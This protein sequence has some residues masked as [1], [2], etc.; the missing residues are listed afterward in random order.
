MPVYPEGALTRQEQG[1]TPKIGVP[2]A[3]ALDR[4]GIIDLAQGAMGRAGCCDMSGIRRGPTRTNTEDAMPFIPVDETARVAITY[5][6]DDGNTAVNVIHITTEEQP[7]TPTVL[8]EMADAIELWLGAEWEDYAATTWTA[9]RLE[10]L[11]L[12]SHNSFYVDRSISVPGIAT[13]QPMPSTVTIAVSLR[14]AFSGRSRRGRLYHVGLTENMVE[15]DYLTSGDATG[16]ITRYET[17]KTS[18]ELDGFRWC[19]VSYVSNGLPRTSG[20]KTI[21]TDIVLT[22][23][24]VDRQ[25]RRKPRD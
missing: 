16:L 25:N 3:Q 15:G 7:V 22:D 13:G 1:R 4:V 2:V 19:V 8:N 11:D 21:I 5:T 18:L 24:K 17:L 6:N 10:L 9:S 20:L 14:S 12:T 23:L